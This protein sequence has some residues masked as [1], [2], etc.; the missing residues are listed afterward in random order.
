MM[1][2]LSLSALKSAI[3]PRTSIRVRASRWVLPSTSRPNL[4]SGD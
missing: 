4:F 3:G 2:T 1:T